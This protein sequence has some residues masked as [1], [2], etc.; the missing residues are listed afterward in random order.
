MVQNYLKR[1]SETSSPC[2]SVCSASLEAPSL[3]EMPP[4]PPAER[5]GGPDHRSIAFSHHVSPDQGSTIC[6][7]GERPALANWQPRQGVCLCWLQKVQGFRKQSGP[8][9]LAECL[10][11]SGCS[12]PAC[13]GQTGAGPDSELNKQLGKGESAALGVK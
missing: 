2:R 13:S 11:A 3:K 10:L 1:V 12:R 5:Q 8:R 6:C 4:P 9:A 7:S